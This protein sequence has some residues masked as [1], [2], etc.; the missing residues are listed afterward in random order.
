MN[1]T[2]RLKVGG[3]AVIEGVM[4]RTES[5]LAV[6]VR[7]ADGSIKTKEEY[8]TPLSQR[9]PLL[10]KPMLRG[11]V[12]L[13]ESLAHGISALTFSANEAA[14]AEAEAP[15]SPW[16][17]TLTIIVS[18]GLGVVLFVVFPHFLTILIGKGFSTPMGINTLLF[19]LI[20]GFIKVA[21]FVLYILGISFMPDI[22]RVFMYHG[23]EHKSIFAFEAGEELTV[24]NARKYSTLHP[25]C[26]TSFII[27]VLLISI[28]I[29][30][31]VFPFMPKFPQLPAFVRNLIYVLIKIPLLLP[32]AGISYELI[33]LA[34][35]RKD[36]LFFIILSFPGIWLQ[37]ITTR[38]PSDDQIEVALTALSRSIQLYRERTQAT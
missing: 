22:R 7:K 8:I 32:I 26:G 15:L 25:R 9:Y 12:V 38:E 6:S 34:G 31:A 28:F 20:D 17:M 23:A 2:E 21:V 19:H 16:A 5:A 14:E 18:L 4:M 35:D 11:V 27:T 33:R 29:F 37:K 36:N 3:Q 24:Q 1:T 30:A 10:K 13:F